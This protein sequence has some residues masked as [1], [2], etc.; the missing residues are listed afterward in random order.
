MDVLVQVCTERYDPISASIRYV[1]RS[2]F[3]HVEFVLPET[4]DT[5]GARYIGGVKWRPVSKSRHYTY[6]ERYRS[7]YAARALEAFETQAGKPYDLSA[8]FGIALDRDWKAEDRW[9]CSEGLAWGF[10]QA[11]GPL[12]NP[13]TKINRIFPSHI[14]MSLGLTRVS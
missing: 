5:F 11:R 7:P 1:T 10:L 8:I 4:G 14:P 12:F 9:F 2:P 3:S 6:V 13:N